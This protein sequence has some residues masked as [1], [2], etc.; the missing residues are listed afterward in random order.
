MV[1]LKNFIVII[2][3]LL[4]PVGCGNQNFSKD[5][6]TPVSGKIMVDKVEYEMRVGKYQWNGENAKIKMIDEI[7][8]VEIAKDFDTLT[9]EKN[10][11]IDIVIVL[12]RILTLLFTNGVEE[13]KVQEI[14][15]TENQIIVPSPQAMVI[16]YT[17]WWGNGMMEKHHIYLM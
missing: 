15:L 6:Q 8:P 11:T 1:N 14:A 5:N 7:S 3:L 13:G 16:I 9:L 12:K 4:T 2:L 10:K 17:K